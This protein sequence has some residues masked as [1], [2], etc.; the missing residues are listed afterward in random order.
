MIRS[1]LILLITFASSYTFAQ[2]TERVK[3]TPSTNPKVAKIELTNKAIPAKEYH[4]ASE[5][6]I[7]TLEHPEELNKEQTIIT[8]PTVTAIPAS[9]RTIKGSSHK[10]IVTVIDENSQTITTEK[11]SNLTQISSE[12][13]PMMRHHEATKASTKVMSTE[14]PKR[15]I[16]QTIETEK[17][18]EE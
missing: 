12:K 13:K 17:N 2:Q 3:S 14:P 5:H 11:N 10:K 16:I 6:K 18:H 15:V 9:T 4:Q 7:V 8:M 1:T